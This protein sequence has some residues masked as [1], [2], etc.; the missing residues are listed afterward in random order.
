[1]IADR[2]IP[3]DLD[4]ASALFRS[5]FRCQTAAVIVRLFEPPDR[6]GVLV[7]VERLQEGVAP[8]RDAAAVRA[9]MDGWV[10]E[11]VDSDATDIRAVFVAEEEG[12]I[13]GFATASTRRH[14]AGDIDAYVGE[15]A[16]ARHFERRGVGRR[17]MVAA[18]EW[19]RRQGLACVSL[20]TGAANARARAFYAALGYEEEDVRLTKRLEA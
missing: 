15:L 8:W 16:V 6:P 11:A 2:G 7:L 17:L 19:A 18:E 10:R 1:M 20:D 5:V 13:V 4:F 12:E 9:A 3:L 14:F